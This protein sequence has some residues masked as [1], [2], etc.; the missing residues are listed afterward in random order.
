RWFTVSLYHA[1][2]AEG[3][4][5]THTPLRALDFESS[6]SAISPLRLLF[7]WQQFPENVQPR[8]VT[9]V[10][11]MNRQQRMVTHHVAHKRCHRAEVRAGQSELRA[12]VYRKHPTC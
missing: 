11:P 9:V 6:A 3:G 1:I 4:S 10:S 2:S 8:Q 5:R 7:Y 12:F